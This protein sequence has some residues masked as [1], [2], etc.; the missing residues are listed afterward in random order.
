MKRL[1]TYK[2]FLEEAEF[3]VNIND[4]PDIKMAKE[5]LTTLQKQLKEYKEKKVQ[6][7]NAYLKIEN[8]ADLNLKIESIVGKMDTL[9]EADRNPFLVEYL[10]IAN[11][12]RKI[13]KLQKGITQDKL[14]KDDFT[15]ELALAKDDST[16]KTV[17]FKISDIANRIST[18]SATIA[19]LTKDINNYQTILDKKLSDIEK[20]MKDNIKNISKESTK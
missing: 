12:K 15:Q 5:K 13:D 2:L 10:H 9:P 19:Q 16:K 14:K 4:E 1:K 17:S 20:N 18:N 8:D 6:I 3:D 11:L 7:D